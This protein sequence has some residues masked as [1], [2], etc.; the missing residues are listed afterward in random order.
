M[1]KILLSR[2]EPCTYQWGMKLLNVAEGS[3]NIKLTFEHSPR[4]TDAHNTATNIVTIYADLVV[5]ADGINSVVRNIRDD[6][7][8]RLNRS[9]L[10]YIGISVIIGLSKARHPFLDQAGFY[11]LDGIHRL[12]VMPFKEAFNNSCSGCQIYSASCIQCEKASQQQVTMWQL[13][14]SGL[15]EIEG[16]ALKNCSGSELLRESMRRVSTWFDPVSALVAHTMVDDVWATPLYDRNPMYIPAKG[17]TPPLRKDH[18]KRKRDSNSNES[19]SEFAVKD[20]MSVSKCQLAD[21]ITVLGDA[22]MF[23]SVYRCHQSLIEI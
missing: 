16:Q 18:G 8:P 11:V 6:L 19:N 3:S 10:N 14:F 22:C 7:F 1:R 12:F 5:G 17:K 20:L 13:S 9:S 23:T 2:L 15:S 21:R 4:S